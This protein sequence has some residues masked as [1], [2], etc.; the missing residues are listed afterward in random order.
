ML[1]TASGR[2]PSILAAVLAILIAAGMH[3][4]AAYRTHKAVAIASA[5]A[6]T[7]SAELGRS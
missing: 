3:L 4:S 7:N 6:H 5:Q 2:A 1:Y